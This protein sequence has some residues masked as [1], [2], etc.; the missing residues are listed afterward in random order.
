[1][2][3]LTKVKNPG[4]PVFRPVFP[5]LRINRIRKFLRIPNGLVKTVNLIYYLQKV[6]FGLGD[7]GYLPLGAGR[8]GGVT[9]IRTLL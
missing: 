5:V 6:I 1:M 9:G 7:G 8:L 4:F 3:Y 2:F